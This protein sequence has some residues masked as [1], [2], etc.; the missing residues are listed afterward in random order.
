MPI[1]T[2]TADAE[3]GPDAHDSHPFPTILPPHYIIVPMDISSSSKYPYNSYFLRARYGFSS[4]CAPLWR[5]PA[6]FIS[7]ASL[8]DPSTFLPAFPL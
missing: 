2:I 1:C 7:P 3:E 5:V 8:H 6:H 4:L